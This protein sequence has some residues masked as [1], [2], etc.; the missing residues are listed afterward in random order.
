MSFLLPATNSHCEIFI[1]EHA[2]SSINDNISIIKNNNVYIINYLKE[3]ANDNEALIEK[4]E[5]SNI[6][7]LLQ[8]LLQLHIKKGNKK[9]SSIIKLYL[10]DKQK[11]NI[12]II[13]KNSINNEC[14]FIDEKKV[15]KECNKGDNF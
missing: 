10:R 6:D 11:L 8:L 2:I 5:F 9:L 1:E 3:S 13:F 4:L 14:C 7:D 15:G 12:K